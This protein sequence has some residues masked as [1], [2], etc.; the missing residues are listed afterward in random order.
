M[1]KSLYCLYAYPFLGGR[2][3]CD[4]VSGGSE[5]TSHVHQN[6]AKSVNTPL[7]QKMYKGIKKRENLKDVKLAQTII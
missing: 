4:Y 2:D 1:P 6:L 7:I 3:A 5:H